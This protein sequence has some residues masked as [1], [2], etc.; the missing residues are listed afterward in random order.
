MKRRAELQRAGE[1]YQ[2]DLAYGR[3][4]WQGDRALVLYHRP[5]TDEMEVWY[6]LP[7]VKPVLVLKEAVA[8]FD[9]AKLCGALAYA[10]NRNVSV[11]Q[12]MANADAKNDAIKADQARQTEDQKDEF[13]DRMFHAVRRDTGN[14]ISPLTV[15]DKMKR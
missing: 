6:E 11:E 14:H 9:I 2:R 7:N 3:G 1:D 10:D 4:D 8:D 5:L 15:S 12:K 13:T